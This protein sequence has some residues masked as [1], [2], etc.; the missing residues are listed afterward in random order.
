LARWLHRIEDTLLAVLVAVLIVG[1]GLQVFLRAFF[2]IGVVWLD[3]MLR[4]L[5]LWLAMLGALAAARGDRHIS[6]EL[7]SRFLGERGQR[8]L[9]GFGLLF[10]AAVCG[11]LAWHALTLVRMEMGFPQMAFAQVPT[12]VVMI[13]LPAGFALLALRLTWRAFVRAEA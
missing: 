13:I 4:S 7:V 11:L 5:V 1:A 3:P 8:V 9:R 2:D 12:W 6:I 10:A